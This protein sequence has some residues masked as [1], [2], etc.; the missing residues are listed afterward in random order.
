MKIT[1][2]RARV[3][4]RRWI[5]HLSNIRPECDSTG[6]SPSE[7]ISRYGAMPD[8]CR[9]RA[10]HGIAR[11]PLPRPCHEA[12]GEGFAVMSGLGVWGRPHT[13]QLA[14]PT[15]N[16]A[17]VTPHVAMRLGPYLHL[18]ADRDGRRMASEDSRNLDRCRR[19]MVSVICAISTRP[20]NS[21][22]RPA[23]TSPRARR[24]AWKSFA[25][26]VTSGCASKNGTIRLVQ[27]V[28]ALDRVSGKRFAVVVMPSIH[29]DPT[30]AR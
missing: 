1:V 11:R 21:R 10:S 18:D 4:P 22:C 7:G 16:F 23:F 26:A 30:T 20:S 5:C 29:H 8:M 28:A 9:Q 17:L 15:R 19:F 27:I 12:A 14:Y 25:F 6:A 3:L 2:P 24:K 13:G